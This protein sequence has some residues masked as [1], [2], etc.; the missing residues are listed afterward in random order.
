MANWIFGSKATPEVFEKRI[1][2]KKWPIFKHTP[3][4]TRLKNGDKV[5]FYKAGKDGQKFIGTASIGSE[6]VPDNLDYYVTL[7]NIQF[8]KKPI[9]VPSIL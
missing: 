1:S 2:G 7:Y 3:N 6:I 9:E 5:V 8:W 4:K